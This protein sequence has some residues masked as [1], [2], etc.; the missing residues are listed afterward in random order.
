MSNDKKTILKEA[1]ITYSEIME[2][3]KELSNV[4]SLNTITKL[5]KENLETN[6]N[7]EPVQE[8]FID[9]IKQEPNLGN[10]TGENEEP[11]SNEDPQIFK[12]ALEDDSENGDMDLTKISFE[13]LEEV[14]NE[15]DDEDEFETAENGLGDVSLEDLEKEL[16]TTEIPSEEESDEVGDET[17]TEIETEPQSIEVE[18]NEEESTLTVLQTIQD[19]IGKLIDVLKDK[20]DHEQLSGEFDGH[21]QSIYGDQFREKLGEDYDKLFTIYKQNK[22]NTID[23]QNPE[24][25]SEEVV[26]LEK[27]D[28][29][30]TPDQEV[31]ESHGSSL[32]LNK[33]AGAEVQPRPEF[34]QY[35]ENKYRPG[36][37]EGVDK[38]IEAL[39]NENKKLK[40]ELN[41]INESVNKQNTLVENY[42]NALEKYRTRLSEM[43]VFNTNLANVNNLLV[44]EDLSLNINDKIKI[45]ESFK[46]VSNIEES[47]QKYGELL[48]E[49]KSSSAS[50]LESI[51]R[52][53][54]S[55]VSTPSKQ[56]VNEVVEATSYQNPEIKKMLD[57]A[58]YN[59]KK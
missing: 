28:Q 32:S 10:E 46:T 38:R 1:A 4:D 5:I 56:L 20:D 22:M 49:M 9:D 47:K 12:E 21:M 19:E 15:A 45:I 16:S 11:T 39:I 42:A 44:N 54:D 6:I 23:N 34:A 36:V 29:N 48:N 17:S 35:K 26:D 58:N 59:H 52:K 55:S 51:T 33:R 3:A 30:N 24:L 40:K 27:E 25:G 31:D 18:E 13:K 43:V 37:N 7:K 8:S 14:F 53:I 50:N 41:T 57:R 2:K